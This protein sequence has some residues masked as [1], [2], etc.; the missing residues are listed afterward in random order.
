MAIL[1]EGNMNVSKLVCIYSF[2]PELEG[3]ERYKIIRLYGADGILS[4]DDLMSIYSQLFQKNLDKLLF[5]TYEEMEK[6]LFLVI[7]EVQ[8]EGVYCLSVE[9]Y[10]IAIDNV[11]DVDAFKIM[12]EKFGTLLVLPNIPKKSFFSKFK[13]N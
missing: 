4:F 2:H 6:F 11:R 3:D 8:T 13:K 10:N 7:E 12:P 1:N 9:D 5:S